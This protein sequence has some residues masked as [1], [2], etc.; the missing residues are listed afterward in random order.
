MEE[1]KEQLKQSLI[2][3]GFGYEEKKIAMEHPVDK[4][5]GDYSSNVAMTLAVVEKRNPRELAW[6]LKINSMNWLIKLMS[7]TK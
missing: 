5:F 2:E 1:I 6:K 7:L 3:L 4:K